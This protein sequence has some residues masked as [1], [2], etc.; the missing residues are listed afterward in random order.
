MI[1]Q[2]LVWEFRSGF[3]SMQKPDSYDVETLE[4]LN[5][6]P[7]GSLLVAE[8]R[9][10]DQLRRVSGIDLGVVVDLGKAVAI[11]LPLGSRLPVRNRD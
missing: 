7:A 6:L 11:P 10:V 1:D 3:R 5:A 8:R 2:P 4:I 9:D